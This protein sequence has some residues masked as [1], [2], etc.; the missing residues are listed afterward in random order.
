MGKGLE[1]EK[2]LTC[3]PMAESSHHSCEVS[4]VGMYQIKDQIRKKMA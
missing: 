4:T 1:I 3:S 2:M